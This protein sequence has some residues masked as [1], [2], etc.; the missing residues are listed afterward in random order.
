M[1]R[2]KT[3]SEMT[4]WA[5]VSSQSCLMYLKKNLYKSLIMYSNVK[6]RAFLLQ[7]RQGITIIEHNTQKH[8]FKQTLS[9]ILLM[10]NYV[11]RIKPNPMR[12]NSSDWQSW[13]H[14]FE[15]VIKGQKIWHFTVLIYI[16]KHV[17]SLWALGSVK[18]HLQAFWL[19]LLSN[20]NRKPNFI[21]INLLY[22]AGN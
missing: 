21:L 6:Q 14:S 4:S 2:K 16:S 18:G 22:T 5:V 10:N 13:L 11:K 7:I 8:C 1:S 17:A 12:R 19:G 15:N 3:S 20:T 9:F